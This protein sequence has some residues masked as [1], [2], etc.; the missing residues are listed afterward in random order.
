MGMNSDAAG[1]FGAGG[2]AC[3]CTGGEEEIGRTGPGWEASCGR[4]ALTVEELGPAC[5]TTVLE[6]GLRGSNAIVALRGGCGTGMDEP[7]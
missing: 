3:R 2:G 5:V 6:E 4:V 1:F 7:T